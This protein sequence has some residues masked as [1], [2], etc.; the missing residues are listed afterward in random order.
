MKLFRGVAA[1]LLGGALAL[2]S[3]GQPVGSIE[4]LGGTGAP[5]YVEGIKG[6]SQFNMPA[7]LAV[8]E[9]GLL[10]IADYNNNAI[11]SMRLSDSKVSTFAQASHPVG[12]AFDSSTNL[13]IANQGD[14]TIT[15]YDY[16]GN[17][18]QTLRPVLNA[19]AMTALAIDRDD[20][21]YV[22]QL[23]GVVARINPSGFTDAAFQAPT[24]GTHEF[25]GV[26]VTDDGSIFVSD[27]AAHVIWRF[28]ATGGAEHFA[29]T[30]NSSGDTEGE[31]GFGRLNRPN[32]IAVG[33]NSSIVVADRGNQQVR[34]ISC[35]G[36]ITTLYGVDP[37]LWFNIPG[38]GVFPGWWDSSAEFAELREPMG[39]AVDKGGNVYDTEAYYHLVRGARGLRFPLACG[40]G[41]GGGPVSTNA[42]PI[43]VLQ[44]N[45]GF[46]PN[47]VTITI[48]ASNSFSGFSRDTR[49]FYTLDASEP[50]ANDTEI[51]I[52]PDGRAHLTLAGPI[53]LAKLR[54]RA[55]IG[56]I[57]SVVTSAVPT[58][59]PLPIISPDAGYYPMGVDV[60][61]TTAN[62][63]PE[64]ALLYYT[65]DGTVPTTNSF[66][67]PHDA[68]RGVINWRNSDRDLRSLRVKA[69]LGPNE[70]PVIGGRSISFPGEPD[71]QGEIGIPPARNGFNAGI[72]S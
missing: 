48:S 34:V 33:P 29:G 13:F 65:T 70:G 57:A 66:S 10:F 5:G 4:T 1:G 14:G 15:K 40:D 3:F 19:G 18:R 25:R 11:R 59:V 26:A 56:S 53:D 22:A 41:T 6:R 2:N 20:N 17:F 9:D 30:I 55:F 24:G 46:Y 72:G 45:S 49:I 54:V 38:P 69:F 28:T 39:V 60:A 71:I 62:G 44:P 58:Q 64:G 35:Q 21:L 36:V 23:G 32:Q 50:D 37:A 51:G 7:G 42:V 63:F 16:F 43:P 47:G 27:S 61:V 12:V 8:R 52:S 31:R 67:I 68:S